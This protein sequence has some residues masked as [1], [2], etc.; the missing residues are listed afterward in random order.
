M[1]FGSFPRVP[2]RAWLTI[3]IALW[4]VATAAGL[5]GLLD[6]QTAAGSPANPPESWPTSAN[7]PIAHR[8]P[9]LLVIAHPRC[10]CT[11][12]TIEELAKIMARARGS[13]GASVIFV[14]PR[15]LDPKWAETDMYRAASAIPGVHTYLDTD[16]EIARRFGAATSGQALL[17]G[18][19]GRLRFAGGITMGRGHGG[20]NPGSD[21]IVSIINS[22]SV[23]LASTP[24]FGCELASPSS[25]TVEGGKSKWVN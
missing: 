24:V 13:I 9:T 7:F 10:P 12:A 16:G 2:A 4:L 14:V 11:R 6:Y 22:H 18:A 17:Y 20:D 19:D 21:A 25:R 8:G 5:K 1:P 15:G 3:G 23:K